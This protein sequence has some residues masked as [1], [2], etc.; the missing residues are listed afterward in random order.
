MHV[1]R[2][3]QRKTLFQF[4]R[5]GSFG[6]G[7]RMLPSQRLESDRERIVLRTRHKV[8]PIVDLPR[9]QGLEI[10]QCSAKVRVF[11]F[12]HL[13]DG[14]RSLFPVV[15]V[16]QIGHEGQRS[17]D[18]KQ[19]V[20]QGNGPATRELLGRL[21]QRHLGIGVVHPSGGQ[22]QDRGQCFSI[23]WVDPEKFG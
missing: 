8:G 21:L 16:K 11:A 19:R 17:F 5:R 12:A 4:S 22:F 13:D 6:L 15:N 18:L 23:P 1:A 2:L 3:E 9:L 20:V 14:S 7:R 10:L